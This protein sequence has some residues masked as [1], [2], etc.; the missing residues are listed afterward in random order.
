M[1][2][3]SLANFISLMK[4]ITNMDFPPPSN[5]HEENHQATE[6][7]SVGNLLGWVHTYM[8]ELKGLKT[9]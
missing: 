8:E 6:P 3:Y 5:M 9:Y 2:N 1:S 4:Q 7:I